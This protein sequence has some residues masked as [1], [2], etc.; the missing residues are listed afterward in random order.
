[1]RM[2]PERTIHIRSTHRYGF[3]NG[4]WAEVHDVRGHLRL[5]EFRLVYA[6]VFPDGVYD[7]WPVYDPS[8]PYEFAF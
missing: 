7:L 1:M 2:Q 6:V 3:R 5:D 8:D 4:Q